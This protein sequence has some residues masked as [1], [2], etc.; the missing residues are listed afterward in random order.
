[1]SQRLSD[2]F[3]RCARFDGEP[4]LRVQLARRDVGKGV[5]LHP[6]RDA[7]HDRHALALRHDVT[8]ELELVTTVDDYGGFG[9]VRRL[10]V[11]ASLVVAY[12]VDPVTLASGFQRQM[13][14]TRRHDVK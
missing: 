2:R 13:E 11:F 8:R 5:R 4:E 1:M 14:L 10:Q 7:Q 6:R 3:E 12:K 9:P